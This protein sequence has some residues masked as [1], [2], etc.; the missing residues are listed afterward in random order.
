MEQM[1]CL[2]RNIFTGVVSLRRTEENKLVC[3]CCGL[4]VHD[5]DFSHKY[6]LWKKTVKKHPGKFHHPVKKD[7]VTICKLCGEEIKHDLILY[8]SEDM[9]ENEKFVNDEI[10]RR[11]RKRIISS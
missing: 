9:S 11:T 7:G 6:E 8:A 1:K 2:H 10:I 3:E 4:E 5:K